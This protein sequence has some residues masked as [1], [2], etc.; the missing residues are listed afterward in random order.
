VFSSSEILQL[1]TGDTA[2]AIFPA[3]RLG[4]LADGYEA[5]FLVLEANP[6]HDLAAVRGIVL[7]VKRGAILP[8]AAR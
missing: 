6:L 2:R 5:S 8:L 4:R 1:A 7:R 3:R